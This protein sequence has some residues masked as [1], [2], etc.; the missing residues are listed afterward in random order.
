M[1]TM[2]TSASGVGCRVQ[3]R[4]TISETGNSTQ[5]PNSSEPA[6]TTIGS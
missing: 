3:G 6:A 5:P 2:E 4:S 1:A